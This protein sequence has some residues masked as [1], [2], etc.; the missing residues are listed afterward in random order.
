MSCAAVAVTIV[1]PVPKA[2]SYTSV[3]GI[4]LAG[5]VIVPITVPDAAKL[6]YT[7]ITPVATV[8]M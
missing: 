5:T 7:V 3:T 1:S 6:S 2:K 8:E 4:G